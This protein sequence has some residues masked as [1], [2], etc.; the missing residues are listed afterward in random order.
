M[1]R[2]KLNAQAPT[3]WFQV[4]ELLLWLTLGYAPVY[5]CPPTDFSS[6][7]AAAGTVQLPQ[8][9]G[10]APLDKERLAAINL[11]LNAR[12]KQLAKVLPDLKSMELTEV[13]ATTSAATDPAR[14]A[15]QLRG[16]MALEQAT[17]T[18]TRLQ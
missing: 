13:T 18:T 10:W 16:I 4:E 5:A 2:A 15:R 17:S 9:T 6:Q 14:L 12:F 8:P 3:L 7:G 1:D 11:L